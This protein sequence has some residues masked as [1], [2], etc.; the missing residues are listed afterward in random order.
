MAN[1]S[2]IKVGNSTYNI[3]S[4]LDIGPYCTTGGVLPSDYYKYN[5]NKGTQPLECKLVT[6]PNN[7]NY[8]GSIDSG[9]YIVFVF[10]NCPNLYRYYRYYIFK[11]ST[12]GYVGEFNA[13]NVPKAISIAFGVSLATTTTEGLMSAADKSK[14]NS[15]DLTDIPSG[16][17]ISRDTSSISIALC[18][19][20]EDISGTY[21]IGAATAAKAG[22]MSAS[23]KVKLDAISDSGVV[24][25]DQTYDM[26]VQINKLLS[27]SLSTALP[28][29]NIDI[30]LQ[31]LAKYPCVSATIDV[32]NLTNG[33]RIT[34]GYYKFTLCGVGSSFTGVKE[35]YLIG[36]V[37]YIGDLTSITEHTL[38]IRLEYQSYGH[39]MAE[40]GVNGYSIF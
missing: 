29:L 14:L 13:D 40:W 12:R 39:G 1:I 23:D 32:S 19:D 6:V 4:H 16:L 18:N 21:E 15:L 36:K 5:Y 22:V 35:A 28:Y 31:E 11:E 24:F 37:Y 34:P 26:T 9:N 8:K 38:A 10:Y 33:T 25:A 7:S 17:N 20:D 30:T 27:T 2:Q 3:T